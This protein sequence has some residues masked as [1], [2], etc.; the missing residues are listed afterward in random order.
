MSGDKQPAGG[1]AAGVCAGRGDKRRPQERDREIERR[2]AQGSWAFGYRG[3][4]KGEG[5]VW[6][7]QPARTQAGAEARYRRGR[8][9]MRRACWD[10]GVRRRRGALSFSTLK[11]GAIRPCAIAERRPNPKAPL[12]LS[13][14]QGVPSVTEAQGARGMQGV[15]KIFSRA[16]NMAS[17][18]CVKWC[19]VYDP[20]S[21]TQHPTRN[22]FEEC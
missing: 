5:A 8:H 2:E 7:S 9:A 16:V 4:P 6:A 15:P 17:H 1:E 10:Q 11:G 22:N 19:L 14:A 18:R 21:F 12:L 20:P 13:E 3:D